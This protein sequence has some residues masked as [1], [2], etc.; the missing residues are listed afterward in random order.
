[1]RF[2]FSPVIFVND[3][4]VTHGNFLIL[5]LRLVFIPQAP[6]KMLCAEKLIHSNVLDCVFIEWLMCQVLG[7]VKGIQE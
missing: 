7:E 1:M 5:C 6:S 2:R 4:Q 3:V